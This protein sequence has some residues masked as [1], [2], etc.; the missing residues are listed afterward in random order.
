MPP[1]GQCVGD[2]GAIRGEWS[3]DIEAKI[4]PRYLTTAGL[5]EPRVGPVFAVASE[6]TVRLTPHLWRS[7]ELKSDDDRLLVVS[8]ARRRGSSF[9][10]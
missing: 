8:W 1:M 2:G 4:L 6:V 7:W 9:C 5:E 10:L 3:K